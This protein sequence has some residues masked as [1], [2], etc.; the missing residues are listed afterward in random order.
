[1]AP[2]VLLI[3]KPVVPPYHDGS[4]CLVREISTN[5]RS[6]AATVMVTRGD[7][8]PVELQGS[9]GFLSPSTLAVYR[10][11]SGFTPALM[12]NAQVAASLLFGRGID[13]WHFVFAPNP[14][15]SQVG[16][17]LRRVRGI[18]VVQTV[19]SAPQNLERID[20]LLFGDV[21]VAQSRD[22][23]TRIVEACERRRVTPPRLQV[24]PPPVAAVPTPDA[25]EVRALGE[26]LGI[27]VGAPTLVYPGDLEISCGAEKFASLIEPVHVLLPDTHFVFACRMKTAAA[28]AIQQDLQA[29][30]PGSYVHFAGELPS[31]PVLYGLTT[32]VL[33]PVDDLTNKVDLPIA[34]L[35]AMSLGVPV[36][37]ASRGPL[38]DLHGSERL[39]LDPLDGWAHAAHRLVTDVGHA[40]QAAE[41]GRVAVGRYFSAER[42]AASYESLYVDLAVRAG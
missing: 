22:T 17:F 36:L 1:M 21:V 33:F 4:K 25:E 20:E 42:V 23:E 9:P 7:R 35:E 31:L 12:D 34:L 39:P 5:L 38:Q 27:P 18:P 8:N 16:R 41:A 2:R 29:R 24:I 19:A 37:A 15:T 6:V 11:E 32:A 28:G 13:L 26:Q 40:Q 30:F 14:R 10:G 3:S